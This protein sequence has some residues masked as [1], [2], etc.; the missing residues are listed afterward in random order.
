LTILGNI[1]FLKFNI[2]IFSM[3][4]TD[5]DLQTIWHGDNDVQ[6]LNQETIKNETKENPVI[7]P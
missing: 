2:V 7:C 3:S 5:F 4:L 1:I 6:T